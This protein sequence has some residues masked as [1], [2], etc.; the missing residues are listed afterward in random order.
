MPFTYSLYVV[1]WYSLYIFRSIP[2]F[3]R[4]H[5][6]T[7]KRWKQAEKP[8]YICTKTSFPFFSFSL[9]FLRL[10]PRKCIPFNFLFVPS[11]WKSTWK[12]KWPS[13]FFWYLK[14]TSRIGW[15]WKNWLFSKE[16]AYKCN[17]K[18]RVC[19]WLHLFSALHQID[20]P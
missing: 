3:V 4:I 5:V 11:K 18:S 7:I 19:S 14:K 9:G 6:E 2:G 13:F 17:F 12:I 8:S 20:V 16:I 1:E 10:W 15:L